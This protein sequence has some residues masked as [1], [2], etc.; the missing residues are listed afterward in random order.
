[1]GVDAATVR[2]A[3]ESVLRQL[4]D[5]LGIDFS[6]LRHNDFEARA[7]RLTAEWPPRL[8]VPDPDPLA[9]VYFDDADSV[10]RLA[11]TLTEPAVFRPDPEQEDYR[12]RV[13]Q[14][15]GFSATSMAVVPLLHSER[16]TGILGFIKIGDRS[17]SEAELNALKAIAALLSQ[18]Q[19]RVIA[20]E[21]LR[22]S[23][24]HDPLTKLPNRTALAQHLRERLDPSMPG[25][26]AVMHI[27]LDRLKALNDFLGHLAGDHYLET[28]ADRLQSF[29]G[30]SAGLVARL[31]GDEF[32]VVLA[33]PC[34]ARVATHHAE[35]IAEAVNA[36]VTLGVE[37]ISRSASIG[38][39]FGQPGKHTAESLLRQADQAALVAK[40]AGGHDIALFTEEMHADA[41]LR[42]DVEIHLREAIA[43]DSLTLHFQPEVDLVTGRIT[44]V[45]ALVRWQHPTRGLLPPSAFIPVAEETN[46]AGELGRW[47][48]DHACRT[49]ADWQREIPH[50]DIAMRVNISPVQLVTNGFVGAVARALTEFSIAGPDLC[51]EITEVAVVQ[52]LSRTRVTLS[53]L[54]ELGV[55]VAID[56]FGTGYSSLSHL[57]ELPVDAL[58]IDR[59]FVTDLGNENT[60]D[61]AIVQS[62]IGL[63]RAFGLTII[64]EGVETQSARRTLIELGCT[65]AQGYLFSKPVPA[66]DALELLHGVR[67][68]I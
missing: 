2:E 9:V 28:I 25:P 13:E 27:D 39:A 44:A 59:A 7:T 24:L 20:E 50:L 18:L 22:F 15:S 65:R 55:Q 64:A 3:Y 56:D 11:E 12:R 35:M 38:I 37:R 1:M 53:E 58:K 43:G 32:L 31:G 14:G 8:S 5:Y 16:T 47:V 41:E 49:L 62:I 63:A 10:F 68:D 45:E 48:L 19:A 42:N 60:G 66:D 17:W 46:L 57:K 29:V 34:S 33:G 67:I 61:L 30:R 51:L 54:H 23:A 52:D 4:V 6:F 21:Q 26:V 36:P 40:R